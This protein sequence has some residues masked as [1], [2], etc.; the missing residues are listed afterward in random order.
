MTPY[1]VGLFVE[2][3]GPLAANDSYAAKE[4][5]EEFQNDRYHSPYVVWGREVNLLLLGLWKHRSTAP[6]MEPNNRITEAWKTISK[7][8]K[9]SGLWHNELWTYRIDNGK[10]LP[11]RYPTGSDIQAWNITDLSIQFLLWK[12]NN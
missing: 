10:V 6:G 3:V 7:A 1:P 4:I 12:Q 5:W 8:A 11:S 9:T 2:G